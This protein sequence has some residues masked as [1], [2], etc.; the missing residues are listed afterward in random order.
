M[1]FSKRWVP[2]NQH[3]LLIQPQYTATLLS[4]PCICVR[5]YRRVT[6]REDAETMPFGSMNLTGTSYTTP[7]GDRGAIPIDLSTSLW[8]YQLG[9]LHRK[10]DLL[11][12]LRTK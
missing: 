1:N 11:L 6:I 9:N 4:R 7:D 10:F 8:N 12:S 3:T 2:D 5:K